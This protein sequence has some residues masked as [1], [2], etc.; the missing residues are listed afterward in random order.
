MPKATI[1]RKTKETDITASV[2]ID[3]NG[4][5][6]NRT[7]VGFLDH[8]LDLL[9][10]H[11]N[12]DISV[13]CK[14]DLKI[15]EHHSVEDIAITLG[16]AFDKALGDRSGISRYGNALVPMDEALARC[17]IDLG[18]RSYLVFKAEFRRSKVGDLP[19]EMV[20]HFFSSFTA[21]VKANIH[22]EIL[23][24]SNTHHCIEA[25]FKSFARALSEACR[26]DSK[27]KGVLSTKGRL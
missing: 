13:N 17:A 22:I 8:M 20:K 12:F 2:V 26:R 6:A 19:T 24:G 15:D 11:G 27:I 25:L 14:G 21:N 5:H 16:K 9:A 23:Y 4:T 10:R 7:G 3:G 1:T 18:G